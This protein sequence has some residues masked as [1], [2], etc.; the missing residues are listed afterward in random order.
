MAAVT[1]LVVDG[2]DIPVA[3]S[4]GL[5]VSVALEGNGEL[6]RNCN[7]ALV[8]LTLDTHR[9]RTVTV[10]CTD[11]KAPDFGTKWRGLPVGITLIAHAGLGADEE[12]LDMM[13]DD[14]HVDRDEFGASSSWSM[15][16]REI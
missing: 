7:G 1:R 6:K 4:R 12:D 5:S 2:I 11:I 13:L 8:D 9:K 3:A 15:G 14:W 10:T 16:L